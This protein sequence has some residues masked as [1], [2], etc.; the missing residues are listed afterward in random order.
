MIVQISRFSDGSRRIKTISEVRGLNKD[1]TYN[2]VPIFDLG[3]L[4]RQA[5]GKLQGEIKPTG[6]LPSFI[7]EIESNRLPFP[8]AKFSAA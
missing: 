1:G 4:V 8:R 2:I 7:E 5:D 3:N 6:E